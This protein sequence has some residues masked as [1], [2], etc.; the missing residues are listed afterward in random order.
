[1][2][3]GATGKRGGAGER[4]RV[5]RTRI[6]EIFTSAAVPPRGCSSTQ[7][8]SEVESRDA[9]ASLELRAFALELP[10]VARNLST[11]LRE[12]RELRAAPRASIAGPVHLV[13]T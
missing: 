11:P 7:P 13:T 6:V 8:R 4:Q 3:D 1:M 10:C 12:R 5:A 2:R 9:P